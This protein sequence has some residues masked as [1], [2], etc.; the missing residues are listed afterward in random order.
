K[1]TCMCTASE[2]R[3]LPTHAI[4]REA[5][6]SSLARKPSAAAKT[7]AGP[8]KIV[9]DSITPLGRDVVPD[10]YE[11][12]HRTSGLGASTIAST[13]PE[14]VSPNARPSA[15]TASKDFRIGSE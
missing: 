3:E 7:S 2:N 4:G 11:N 8:S 9:C 5:T 14:C 13:Y 1:P 12:R 6:C 15:C 10:V